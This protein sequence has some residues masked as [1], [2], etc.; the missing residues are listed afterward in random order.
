[1]RN[2]TLSRSRSLTLRIEFD[3][4]RM[5]VN[6][7]MGRRCVDQMTY[8]EYVQLFGVTTHG[9]ARDYDESGSSDATT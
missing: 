3:P 8:A 1:M 4:D 9:N 2:N 7:M 5:F 6:L